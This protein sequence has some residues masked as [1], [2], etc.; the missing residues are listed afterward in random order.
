M[1]IA[2]I[3]AG[4]SGQR[5]QTEIP[6]QFLKIHGLPILM[7]TISAFR[8]YATS[9]H[10]ILVLPEYEIDNWAALISQY[11]FKD[12]N[13]I[14]AGGKTRFHSVQNG[15]QFI[16]E[17]DIVAIHDGVRPAISANIIQQNFIT[18]RKYGCAVTSV[19]VKDSLRKVSDDF[20]SSVDREDFRI[21]QTPQT[22]QGS[23]IR[24][25]YQQEYQSSF[26]D[27]ASVAEQN[28]SRIYLVDGEYRNIKLT[29]SEDLGAIS[30]FLK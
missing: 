20:S 29:T 14:V 30:S 4:G 3:V 24:K 27:D 18:A 21:V 10:I 25:A 15:L 23:V 11:K 12:V 17:D 2:L 26:T 6:K 19:K 16:Q 9:I 1:E 8:N 13:K 28:G 7:H 22:F 5:M